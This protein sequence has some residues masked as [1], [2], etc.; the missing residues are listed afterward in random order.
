[1]PARSALRCWRPLGLIGS[2]EHCLVALPPI[3]PEHYGYVQPEF[4]S[5]PLAVVV[6]AEQ[7]RVY[8]RVTSA[9]AMSGVIRRAFLSREEAERWLRQQTRALMANELWWSMRR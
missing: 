2:V 1:M 5:V 7:L 6:T 3:D 4:R 8:E 9:A